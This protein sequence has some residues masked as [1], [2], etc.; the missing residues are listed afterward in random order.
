MTG[1]LRTQERP[2]RGQFG[3]FLARILLY[4]RHNESSHLP[5]GAE[6]QVL[7]HTPATLSV[8]ADHQQHSP[9]PE[10]S[11]PLRIPRRIPQRRGTNSALAPSAACKAGGALLPLGG[12]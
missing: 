1:L 8:N 10:R 12:F 3:S 7:A 9:A 6:Q 2:K 11:A 5:I 4:L